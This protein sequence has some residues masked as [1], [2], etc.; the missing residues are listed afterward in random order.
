MENII[1]HHV[2][3]K[4]CTEMFKGGQV[5]FQCVLLIMS[6]LYDKSQKYIIS[7]TVTSGSLWTSVMIIKCVQTLVMIFTSLCHHQLDMSWRGEK[8]LQLVKNPC[9]HGMPLISSIYWELQ[10]KNGHHQNSMDVV[11]LIKC[12]LS[13]QSHYCHHPL[14]QCLHQANFHCQMQLLQQSVFSSCSIS[15]TFLKMCVIMKEE[16][17]ILLREMQFLY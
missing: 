11:V 16:I 3:V 17:Y 12:C 4:W 9:S 6:H 7:C 5:I 13:F 14:P 15:N 8:I 2:T 1:F 10:W